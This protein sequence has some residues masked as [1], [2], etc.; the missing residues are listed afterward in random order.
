[1]A[2]TTSTS[3]RDDSFELFDLRVE[4]VCPANRNIM[5]GAKEGDYFTLKG[6][7]LYLPPGQGIS[8]YSLATV[9]PLLPAKQR[10]TASNDWMTTDALLA[11][12][13]PNC[14]SQLK[15]I[16][17]GVRK[18]SHAETTL[19]PLGTDQSVRTMAVSSTGNGN[20]AHVNMM[21]DTVIANL[22]PDG[23]RVI[24]RSLLTCHP[25]ITNSF[26]HETRQYLGQIKAKPSETS[27]DAPSVDELKQTQQIIRCMLGSGL[28]F[29]AIPILSVTTVRGAELALEVH[30]NH[31]S[32]LEV[33]LATLD[34]DLVQAMTAVK[35]TLF[36]N[37]GARALSDEESST[38]VKLLASLKDCQKILLNTP[39]PF[40]YERGILTIS[41]ILGF[42]M[43]NSLDPPLNPSSHMPLPLQAKETFQLGDKTLPRI[44]SGLWQ[45]SSPAWGAAP[46]S[47]ICEG[48]S[49]YAQDGFTAFD[50][51]DHYG[52]AEVIYVSSEKLQPINYGLTVPKGRF[53]SL[54]PHKDKMF[55]ATKYC[56]F[57]PLVV[58]PEAVAANVSE[59]C[60]R[61]Q[62]NVIDLLQFHWQFWDSPQYLD[63]LRHLSSDERV[64]KIGLCNFDTE[65]V[66]RVLES[67]IRVYTNQVQFSLIDS[68]PT[69]K[70]ANVCLNH[71]IKLLT[72]GTLCGGFISDKWL[73]KS[74][75]DLYDSSITPSQRK[76]Y[77]MIHTWG[78]WD[79]FQ[80]LLTAL[81]T[82]AVK[83]DVK[84]SNV[85]TRWVLDFP[86]VGAVIIGARIGMSERTNENTATFGW[87]LDEDDQ[88]V[89]EGVLKKSKRAEMFETMGDCGNEYR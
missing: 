81:G 25:E 40:P 14:P 61:L 68:R 9:L 19:V 24:I 45:M 71:D 79:L 36:V 30:E 2:S 18:F 27:I 8:I 67:G 75:P 28:P 32:E 17:E 43:E 51:A 39:I 70:M 16:R 34:G 85:A 73:N 11:C 56:V 63:A 41:N 80:E 38:I 49:T 65:H 55:T 1:M 4:V 50:M 87:R 23:L 3:S 29:E 10:V 76:Y 37:L 52:D 20:T 69:V 89:I 59:R 83:H 21:T 66:E 44:F 88:A 62:Q 54:H 84:I 26:E 42:G 58:S 5:C 60:E 6:E 22:P 15:I 77:G 13:D 12:P 78:G 74:K 86:Y 46:M 53:R 57:H 82:I 72:Y 48:F 33:L 31:R 35:K 47:K 7:M 64:A